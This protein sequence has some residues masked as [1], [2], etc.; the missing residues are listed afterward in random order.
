L[1]SVLPFNEK[2][3]AVREKYLLDERKIIKKRNN[4]EKSII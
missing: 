2:I 4:H 1:N 3:K